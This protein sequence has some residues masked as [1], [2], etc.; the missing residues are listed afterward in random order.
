M[1]DSKQLISRI[2]RAKQGSKEER[3]KILQ[4]YLPFVMATVSEF[5][6][7][8]V[9]VGDNE[10]F[11]VALT[12][13][14]SAID[15]YDPNKGALVTLARMMIRNRLIDLKRRES[16]QVQPIEDEVIARIST[17]KNME[18][19][20]ILKMEIGSYE[21]A[22]LE[23][24][25]ELDDLIDSCPRHRDTVQR[26]KRLA[27]EICEDESIIH[28]MTKLKALPIRLIRKQCEVSAKVLR[29][30]RMYIIALVMARRSGSETIKNYV[31]TKEVE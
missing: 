2:N 23:Y 19:Q 29:N 5:T 7:R 27:E 28:E 8:Y 13:M 21:K 22:L 14:D 3:E 11:A 18:D 26:M 1:S 10:E 16:A 25:I 12:T 4:E 17:E 20:S 9:T 6:G 30:H 31:R 24:G 15:S